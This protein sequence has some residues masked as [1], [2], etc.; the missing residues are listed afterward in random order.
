[1]SAAPAAVLPEDF[2][3]LKRASEAVGSV[4]FVAGVLGVSISVMQAIIWPRRGQP[5]SPKMVAR[6]TA[7][8]AEMR[9]ELERISRRRWPRRLDMERP[10]PHEAEKPREYEAAPLPAE[11]PPGVRLGVLADTTAPQRDYVAFRSRR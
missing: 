11:L 8:V 2:A 5:L 9:A 7:A 10:E 3:L 4:Y 6:V 1:M